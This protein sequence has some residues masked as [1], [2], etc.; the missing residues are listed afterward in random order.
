M[1]N[2]HFSKELDANSA[3]ILLFFCMPPSSELAPNGSLPVVKGRKQLE[4]EELAKQN[5]T[6]LSLYPAQSEEEYD[7]KDSARLNAALANAYPP[8]AATP[9]LTAPGGPRFLAATPPLTAPGGPAASPAAANA[10]AA[11]GAANAAANAARVATAAAQQA[12]AAANAANAAGEESPA[13]M[14]EMDEDENNKQT[15]LKIDSQLTRI[16]GTLKNRVPPV[17]SLRN[18][19]VNNLNIKQTDAPLLFRLTQSLLPPKN[20]KNKV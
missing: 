4:A 12:T 18:Y 19:M 8:N 3:F 13:P 16:R 7:A 20:K 1:S 9:P 11:A 2:K 10:R 17:K 5:A 14:S 15:L 6:L